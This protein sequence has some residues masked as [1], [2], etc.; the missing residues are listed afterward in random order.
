MLW[1]ENEQQVREKDTGGADHPEDDVDTVERAE[2]TW[3]RPEQNIDDNDELVGE[4]KKVSI[5]QL[6]FFH[7]I[8][9]DGVWPPGEK[10]MKGT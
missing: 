6:I 8:G 10:V 7:G 3:K 2:V 5:P 9:K 1:G 4:G